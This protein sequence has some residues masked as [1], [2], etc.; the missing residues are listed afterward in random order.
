MKITFKNVGQGDSIILELN[1]EDGFDVGVIDCKKVNNENP[2]IQHLI[3]HQVKKILFI[4]LSHPHQDHCS[5]LLELFEFCEKE[6]IPIKHFAHT[7]NVNPIYF[8]WF[9]LDQDNSVFLAKILAKSIQLFRKGLIQHIGHPSQNWTLLLDKNYKMVCLSPSDHEIRQYHKQVKTLRY[10]N[11]TR[12][13]RSANLLS[14]VFKIEQENDFILLT[15]DAEKTTFQ[16]LHD[17]CM[18]DYL[19]GELRLCQIPHHGAL[20]NHHPQFWSD[21]RRKPNCPAVISA[22]EHKQYKHPHVKVVKDFEEMDY[23]IYSTNYIRYSR[24]F[25]ET[26]DMLSLALS[27]HN[28]LIEQYHI[29]ADHTFTFTE[30]QVQEII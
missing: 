24:D 20:A 22:G 28:P 1:R 19:S 9:E 6:Q 13:A 21:L 16:R 10:T 2:I 26:N 17:T 30:G 3:K 25:D 23:R 7:A 5:G 14:T 18:D 27:T 12:C 29:E 15:S 8:K 4:I 11:Q